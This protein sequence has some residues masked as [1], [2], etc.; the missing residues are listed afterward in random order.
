M[1]FK[2]MIRPHNWEEYHHILVNEPSSLNYTQCI[3]CMDSFNK[4]NVHT[5]DGWR[6]TQISGMCEDCF[7]DTCTED[8]IPF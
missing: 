6:E 2:Q 7:D 4:D 5:V 8:D 3:C 1:A